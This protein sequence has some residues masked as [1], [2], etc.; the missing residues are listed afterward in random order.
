PQ[1][2]PGVA[3]QPYPA[4]VV[5]PRGLTPAA[6]AHAAT[7]S[8]LYLQGQQ[9]GSDGSIPVGASTEA[10]SEEYAIGAAAAGYD[11]SALRHGAGPSVMAYLAAHPASACAAEGACGELF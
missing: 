8:L 9:S 11:P 5:F 10:V 1:A 3:M 4:Q 6:E 2:P 7:S